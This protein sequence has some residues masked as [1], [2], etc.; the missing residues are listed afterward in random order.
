MVDFDGG[1]CKWEEY[2]VNHS[3]AN[4]KEIL[5]VKEIFPL[6]SNN[7]NPSTNCSHQPNQYGHHKKWDPLEMRVIFNL[8]G[9]L[10]LC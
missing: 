3:N 4:I 9:P 1:C 8:N 10:R 7:I 5:I 2:E 6:F